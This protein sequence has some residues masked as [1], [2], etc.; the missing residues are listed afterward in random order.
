VEQQKIIRIVLSN[1][2]RV[3]ANIEHF[4]KMGRDL[5][6]IRG[7]AACALQS[8]KVRKKKQ[9]LHKQRKNKQQNKKKKNNY[10]TLKFSLY[11]GSSTLT[12]LTIH[13]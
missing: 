10:D 9:Q 6:A 1:R 4:L 7:E 13:K 5:P 3:A 8:R 11:Q 2:V 12:P